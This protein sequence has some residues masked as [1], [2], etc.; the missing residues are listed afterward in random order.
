[1]R[2]IKSIKRDETFF[3][4]EE[5]KQMSALGINEETFKIPRFK[6]LNRSS[7][8]ADLWN[9]KTSSEQRKMLKNM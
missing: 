3:S 8:I 4:K 2:N 5:S 1:M 7:V 9:G 6:G